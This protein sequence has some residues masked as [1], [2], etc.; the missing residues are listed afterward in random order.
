MIW[1]G[2]ALVALIALA[3]FLLEAWRVQMDTTLQADAPGQFAMLEGGGTHYRWDGP[4]GGPVLVLIHGQSS[5]NYIFEDVVPGLNQ[6]GF[7]TLRYDLWGRGFSD[8]AP[9]DQDE[10]YFCAQLKDLLDQ[11][12]PRG[13]VSLMGFSMGAMIAT[14]F[15][16]K[17]A[18]RV[19]HL[20]LI[21]PAGMGQNADLLLRITRDVPYLGDWVCRWLGAWQLRTGIAHGPW[22]AEMKARLI[23]ETTLRGYMPALTSSLRHTLAETQEAEHLRVGRAAIPVMA[24]W[25]AQD[26]VIPVALADKLKALNPEALQIIV[27][28]ADH[29]LPHTHPDVIVDSFAKLSDD[30][31]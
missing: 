8:R 7:R 11:V 19:E 29:A 15:A 16:A 24:V 10:D 26:Q 21:A 25:G 5:P 12:Q 28:D 17:Y 14:G 27:P 30:F 3:P 6:L 4:E 31:I 13:R 20:G 2:I 23:H 22:S 18:D 9:G 1:A